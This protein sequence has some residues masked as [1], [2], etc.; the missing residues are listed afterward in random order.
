MTVLLCAAILS[1]VV[2]GSSSNDSALAP[3]RETAALKR[4]GLELAEALMKEFPDSEQP[5]VLLGNVCG[6]HGNT[7]KA[8]EFWNKALQLNPKLADVHNNIAWVAMGKG[9]YEDA[10]T[11]WQKALDINPQAPGVHKNVALALM[12]LGRH[13]EVIAELQEEIRISPQSSM[14]YFLLGQEYLQKK[15]Y[16]EAKISYEKAISLQPNHT[17]AYYGLFTVCSRL[18]QP[19]EARRHMA[20]FKRLKAEDMKILKDRNSAFD[21]L[22]SVR[23]SLAETYVEAQRLY[24]KRG[25]PQK[26][27]ELLERA[28][29]LNPENTDSLLEL[30]ALYLASKRIPEA[31]Q[32]SKRASEVEPNNSICHL[33]IGLCSAKLRRFAEAE[34]AFR[35]AIELTPDSSSGY[36]ELALLYLRA[37]RRFPDAR[38]LAE[39]AL[40]LEPIAVNYFVLSFAR[41]RNGD[42]PGAISALK[43]AVE[44]EPGNQLYRQTYE[45][46]LQRK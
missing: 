4:E 29:A 38:Q 39:K 8:I 31:L 14:G 3:E 32:L 30:A 45:R 2:S 9:Q 11:Q 17:N 6:R 10:I 46:I 22:V 37:G 42:S 28:I 27:E 43:R 21:D 1:T 26:A 40:E 18:K 36:R 34:Q 5:I 19:A 33:N 35:K 25:N 16:E 12:A 24:Q 41:D 7:A 44:L 20:T 13:D 23:R 15:E